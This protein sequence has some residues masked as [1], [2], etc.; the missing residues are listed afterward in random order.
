MTTTRPAISV[1]VP[2]LNMAGTIGACLD[3]LVGQSLSSTEREIII[4]DNGSRDGTLDI[5]RRY[6]VTVLEE[7]TP[8]APS[9]RNR[10]IAAAR[11]AFVA[12]TDADCVPSRN[13]LKVITATAESTRAD[14]IAGPMIVIDPHGSLIA[15]YSAAVGQYDPART[16]AHP[17]FPY[18]ATG[19]LAICRSLIVKAGLFDPAFTTFDAAMLFWRIKKMGQ[20]DARVAPRAVV[21]YRTRQSVG[22]FIRQNV[23]YGLGVGRYCRQISRDGLEPPRGRHLAR[24]WGHRLGAARQLARSDGPPAARAGLVGLHVLRELAIA[25]G[26]IAGRVERRP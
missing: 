16:L 5:A 26:T 18:A 7:G 21:F 22:A 3:A 13:W 9:A 6:P 8:G 2:V 20:L 19:N 4:V 11:G 17:R 23:G 15:R 24:S 14:I 10:G 12:F 1:V 25:A